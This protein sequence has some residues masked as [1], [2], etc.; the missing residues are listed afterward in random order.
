MERLRLETGALATLAVGG[1]LLLSACGGGEGASEPARPAS[2]AAPT[3]R[4]RDDARTQADGEDGE[5]VRGE[6]GE[7]GQDGESVRGEDG[8]DG[9]SASQS[10]SVTQSGSGDVSSSI[11]QRSD[12]GSVSSSS[13]S[14]SGSAVKTFS[15]RGETALSFDVEEPSR[16]V[17]TNTR[18]KPFSAAGRGIAI[19]SSAGRGEVSLAPGAYDDVKVRGSNWTIVV[20]PR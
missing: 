15:G 19:D 7:D 9:A 6:D 11:V 16:F 5:S 3:E 20:R 18:G 2:E 4:D 1:C 10:S 12:S 8:A 14:S 13:S 17:W